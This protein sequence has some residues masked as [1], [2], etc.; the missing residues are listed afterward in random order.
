M[1]WQKCMPF[2]KCS[3]LEAKNVIGARKRTSMGKVITR[4]LCL[5][6]RQTVCCPFDRSG[7]FDFLLLVSL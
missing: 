5:V 6:L 1:S 2:P 4:F 7:K 3:N